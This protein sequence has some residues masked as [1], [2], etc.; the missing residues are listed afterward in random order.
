MLRFYTTEGNSIP[1]TFTRFQQWVAVLCRS[2]MHG[3]NSASDGI[4]K[5]KI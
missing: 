5:L 1:L 3:Y 4:S 2:T